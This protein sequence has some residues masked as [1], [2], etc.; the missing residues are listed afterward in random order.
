MRRNVGFLLVACWAGLVP[1]AARGIAGESPPGD[2]RPR[3]VSK[4]RDDFRGAVIP[5]VAKYCASCHGPEKP[6]AGLNL[7]ALRDEATL[8]TRRR[9]WQRIREYVDGGIMPPEDS[10]QPSRAEVDRLSAAIKAALDRDDCGKPANPGRVTIRRLNR[11]EYNNT[12]RDLLGDRRPAGRRVP[13][14]RRRLRLRQHGR[15]PG[16]AAAVDG[17]VPGRGRE[18]RGAGDRGEPG[19]AGPGEARVAPAD[20]LPRA[21]PR[22]ASIPTPPGRSWSGSPAGPTGGR[23]RPRRSAG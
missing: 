7:E 21:E 11:A 5:F 4:A 12:I 17:A 10:P 19:V 2:D 6:K 16:P 20:H 22:R 9:A 13:V 14:R 8:R 3:A 1:G 15:R 23:S 18:D